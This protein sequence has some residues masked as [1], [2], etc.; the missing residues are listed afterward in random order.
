MGYPVSAGRQLSDNAD[1]SPRK[2]LVSSADAAGA[3]NETAVSAVAAPAAF[4]KLRR[5]MNCFTGNDL[6]QFTVLSF[7]AASLPP[8]AQ[9]LPNG[10]PWCAAQ[11]QRGLHFWIKHITEC[12][13]GQEK[14]VKSA[15]IL[16]TKV[17]LFWKFSVKSYEKGP[18]PAS[19]LRVQS[20]A[21]FRGRSKL[22]RRRRLR[23]RLKWRCTP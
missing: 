17:V 20:P 19:C 21:A 4:I 12:R 5:E 3:A 22:D 18:G 1:L 2:Q 14:T 7:F 23:K 6:L 16:F 11:P 10:E 15:Q 8:P 13:S 9:K